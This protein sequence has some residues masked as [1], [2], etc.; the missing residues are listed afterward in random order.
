MR[1]S[2][3]SGKNRIAAGVLAALLL[4]AVVL[5]ALFLAAEA[6]H[7]CCGEDCLICACLRQ[8]EDLLRR[9][10][11]GAD[12]QIAAALCAFFLSAPVLYAAFFRPK[13][14]VAGK[15]RLNN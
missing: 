9:S 1:T 5:G 10:G 6:H 13:T 8:C 11:T 12:A 2:A 7:D 14:P 3:G 15:V 4:A